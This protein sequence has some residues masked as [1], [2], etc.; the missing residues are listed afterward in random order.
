MSR[1][2]LVG[3]V[4]DFVDGRPILHDFEYETA[5]LYKIGDNI[6]ALEDRCSHDDGELA[7]G[8]VDGCEV[9]C[10]RHGA[11]FDI[12][13]GEALTMPATEDV[14]VYAVKVD[15]EDVFVEEPEE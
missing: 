14:A 2:K 10:P 12:R 9:I 7:D 1:W 4:S 5:A 13:T 15:G 3:K 6:F 8:E 11:R